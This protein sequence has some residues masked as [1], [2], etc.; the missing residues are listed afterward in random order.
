[1][2]RCVL[3]TV[4]ALWPSWPARRR[5]RRQRRLRPA[6]SGPAAT[7]RVRRAG[8]GRSLLDRRRG[9]RAGLR[10]LRRRGRRAGQRGRLAARNP[11]PTALG[12]APGPVGRE[13][14]PLGATPSPSASD[15]RWTSAPCRRSTSATSAGKVADGWPAPTRSRPR[16]CRR[17]GGRPGARRERAAVVRRGAG[18]LTGPTGARRCQYALAARRWWP[19]AADEVLAG[20]TS[21]AEPLPRDLRRRQPGVAR[22]RL[23]R[24]H[25]NPPGGRRPRLAAPPL[26]DRTGLRPSRR[27]RSRPACLA[28]DDMLADLDGVIVSFEA[29]LEPAIARQ[30]GDAA[31]PAHGPSD[32]GHRGAFRR[33]APLAAVLADH[34]DGLVAAQ[35]QQQPPSAR[36][37]TEV[38]S[39]LGLTLSFS[40][41]DGDS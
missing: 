15:P 18:T 9:D 38:A 40:D 21:G 36:S 37:A 23:Q 10:G 8:R 5:R 26:G 3:V 1:M 39:L 34:P 22:R 20:W 11:E 27:R 32:G 28:L 30:S 12:A 14:V 25:P 41:A 29:L 35:D 4:V 19:D 6:T 17:R 2:R 16:R 13:P 24:G 7:R 33:A 31:S